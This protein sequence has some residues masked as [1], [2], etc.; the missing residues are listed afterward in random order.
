MNSLLVAMPHMDDPRFERSV[1]LLIKHENDGA[2]GLALNHRAENI[3]VGD[4]LRTPTAAISAS[5]LADMPV[6]IGG[7]VD[8]EHGFV[9][10]SNDWSG[11]NTFK[12]P[13]TELSIT[14][15][16][17]ILSQSAEGK[18]PQE[19]RIMIGYA[20]WSEGQLEDEIQKNLW[21]VIPDASHLIFSTADQD[22]YASATRKIGVDISQ[23]SSSG[24]DA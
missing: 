2:M 7:P 22:L 6:Y 1:I 9:L 15:S 14:Q 11:E 13:R 17:D 3:S 8:S 23:L 20:G 18:G 4:I 21:L 16:L 5:N 12:L 10:H 19:M 24:G